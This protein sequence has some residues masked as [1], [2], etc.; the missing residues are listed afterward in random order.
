M[1]HSR[2]QEIDHIS[3]RQRAAKRRAS[4]NLNL[5]GHKD[6]SQKQKRRERITPSR[7]YM[8]HVRQLLKTRHT[9]KH[10]ATCSL[11]HLEHIKLHAGFADAVLHSRRGL[12]KKRG[13]RCYE[14]RRE[15][16]RCGIP[17]FL[18]VSAPLPDAIF[19]QVLDAMGFNVH[20]PA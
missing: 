14:K 15:R 12:G 2:E 13:G 19:L 3:Q 16:A 8:A 4:L 7:L 9:P 18:T 1:S 11:A 20:E 10:F 17:P 6:E 5:T